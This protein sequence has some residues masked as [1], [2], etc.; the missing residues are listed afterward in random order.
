[1]VRLIQQ[2]KPN[3]TLAYFTALDTTEHASGPFS[4]EEV[5]MLSS[6]LMP[7]WEKSIQAAQEDFQ[8]PG[9]CGR[10]NPITV[11]YKLIMK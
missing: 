11:L 4:Q 10:S 6:A 7:S 2:K 8:R 1:V 5:G 3:L 9:H